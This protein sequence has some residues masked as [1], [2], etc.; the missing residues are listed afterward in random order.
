MSDGE[1]QHLTVIIIR[2][3]IANGLSMVS[4]TR[5]NAQQKQTPSLF[6]KKKKGLK[7]TDGPARLALAVPVAC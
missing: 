5:T 1:K 7:S 4:N 2:H 3:G 6:V